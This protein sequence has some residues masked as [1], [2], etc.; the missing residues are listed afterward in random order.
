MTSDVQYWDQKNTEDTE[1]DHF[2]QNKI[3][4]ALLKEGRI[5]NGT[6]T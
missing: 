1:L 4:I 6:I 5:R 3:S 2:Y